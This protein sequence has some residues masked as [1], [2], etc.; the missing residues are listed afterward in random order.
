MRWIF[1]ILI[2]EWI[3]AGIAL[4]INNLTLILILVAIEIILF[5]V[6]IIYI[7]YKSEK[8]RWECLDTYQRKIKK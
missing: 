1:I 3:L 4:V 2:L 8:E 7:Y 6:Q 5:I